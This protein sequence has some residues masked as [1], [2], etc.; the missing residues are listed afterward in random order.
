LAGAAALGAAGAAPSGAAKGAA[1]VGGEAGEKPKIPPWQMGVIGVGLLAAL[2]MGARTVMPSSASDEGDDDDTTT[3]T[4]DNKTDDGGGGG[5]TTAPAPTASNPVVISSNGTAQVMPDKAPFTIAVAPNPKISVATMAI[6]PTDTST[7]GPGAAAL[8]AYTRRQYSTR[9]KLWNTI[10]IY[11]FSDA[12]SAQYFADY[13]RRR[14]GA[15]LGGSD[16]AYLANLWGTC[17][18]R[19]EY[20]SGRGGKHIERVLYPAK[21]PS[22]WWYTQSN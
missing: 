11:V 8:A 12:Q 22:G 20:S 19:Y 16:Y 21:N 7:S 5:S 2:Y 14:K 6:V 18:A 15:P 4:T 10:Y 13:Q 9:I 3:E 1:P 17:L